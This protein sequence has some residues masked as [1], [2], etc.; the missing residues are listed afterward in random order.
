M[1]NFTVF[2]FVLAYWNASPPNWTPC[3]IFCIQAILFAS[4]LSVLLLRIPRVLLTVFQSIVCRIMNRSKYWND[5][6]WVLSSRMT[7]KGAVSIRLV[8]AFNKYAHN[9][10]QYPSEPRL[11]EYV[12]SVPT[13]ISTPEAKITLT[14]TL[15]R[16]QAQ[17][18]LGALTTTPG[19]PWPVHCLQTSY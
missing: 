3:Q 1:F 6:N 16:R 12:H 18:A 4:A 8:S 14:R 10:S 9:I 5:R 11:G 17:G 2:K 7:K 13:I 15:A 19:V